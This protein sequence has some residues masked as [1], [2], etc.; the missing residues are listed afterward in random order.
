MRCSAS[1]LFSEFFSRRARGKKPQG[2][3]K[4]CIKFIDQTS[5]RICSKPPLSPHFDFLLFSIFF[6]VLKSILLSFI[7]FILVRLELFTALILLPLFLFLFNLFLMEL[8]T[9]LLILTLLLFLFILL[10]LLGPFPPLILLHTSPLLLLPGKSFYSKKQYLGNWVTD[11]SKVAFKSMNF[12]T[13]IYE[14]VIPSRSSG[15][16]EKACPPS[17]PRYLKSLK[18]ARSDRVKAR[19]YM[20]PGIS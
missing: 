17:P 4:N 10:L 14:Q 20:S 9:V 11:T 6:F 2:K 8:F 3:N 12:A 7:L 15:K 16:S 5:C 1:R 19:P 13:T 18:Y